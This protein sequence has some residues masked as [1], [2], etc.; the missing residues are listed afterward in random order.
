VAFDT[1]DL[2][3]PAV[4]LQAVLDDRKSEPR[5][6]AGA[7]ARAINPVETLGQ[8]WQVL[9]RDADSG[10][11]DREMRTGIVTGPAHRNSAIGRRVL[12]G[13]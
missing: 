6:A 7:G 3:V 5:S 4:S 10:V 12:D 8:P 13:I 1:R 11:H 2:E 9:G